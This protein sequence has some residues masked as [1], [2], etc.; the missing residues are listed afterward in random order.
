MPC[1]AKRLSAMNEEQ[2]QVK[3]WLEQET[4]CSMELER[5]HWVASAKQSAYRRNGRPHCSDCA[6]GFVL[7]S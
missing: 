4:C 2:D 6:Q 1:H 5:L 3:P 7:Q